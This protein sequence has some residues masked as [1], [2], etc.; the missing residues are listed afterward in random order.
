MVGG[1]KWMG[2]GLV[3]LFRREERCTYG[4]YTAKG[5]LEG[6]VRMGG[7]GGG[8]YSLR[9]GICEELVRVLWI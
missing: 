4:I 8:G 6:C 5:G 2:A 3:V 7:V 9:K 1:G